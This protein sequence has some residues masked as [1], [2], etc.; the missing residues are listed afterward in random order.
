MSA[1]SLGIS[2][3]EVYDNRFGARANNL[4]TIYSNSSLR[5][6]E[7]IIE[8]DV[9]DTIYNVT[10]N[11]S[12]G[13]DSIYSTDLEGNQSLYDYIQHNYSSPG[14]KTF[15]CTVVSNDGAESKAIVFTLNGLEIEN[16]D[17]LSNNASW[18]VVS[19]DVRNYFIPMETN[20]SMDDGA[21]EYSRVTTLASNE[22]IF[23]FAEQNFSSDGSKT[24]TIS[25]N[26][27]NYT[28]DYAEAF[29]LEGVSIENYNRHSSGTDQI[30]SFDVRNNWNPSVV[31]WNISGV[32]SNS[33]SLDNDELLMVI[34][35]NNYT[36][37][38]KKQAI[39]TAR[40]SSYE[41]TI[42]D[43]FLIQPLLIQSLITLSEDDSEAVSE[44]IVENTINNTQQFSWRLDTQEEN[45]T[46]NLINVSDNIFVYIGSEY[47]DEGVYNIRLNINNTNYN[48]SEKRGVVIS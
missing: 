34:V 4:K 22:N 16:F 32:L 42:T 15:G 28:N 8:N 39:I 48:D 5:T 35:E 40:S 30:F 12:D 19:Y 11:C 25:L 2:D 6:F 20:I 41:D 45:I 43:Y 1:V 38:G 46:S 13:L 44:L 24:F 17:I 31:V 36:V 7:F 3:S 33:S 9:S 10:W 27:E 23:V 29:S 14:Q 47:N 21:A 37:Q 18:R 26:S